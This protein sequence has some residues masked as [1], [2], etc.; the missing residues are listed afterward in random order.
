MSIKFEGKGKAVEIWR[1]P[2]F[3]NTHNEKMRLPKITVIL[4]LNARLH[5]AKSPMAFKSHFGSVGRC[6]RWGKKKKSKRGGFGR[7]LGYCG[8]LSLHFQDQSLSGSQGLLEP[9][10]FVLGKGRVDVEQVT[11]LLQSHTLTPN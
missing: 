9:T 2:Q 8:S 6:G 5:I 11:S 1:G 10:R 4:N 7:S 3:Y